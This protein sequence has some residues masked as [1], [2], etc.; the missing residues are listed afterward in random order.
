MNFKY[1][2][3]F[4][5]ILFL[6]GCQYNVPEEL[7][8]AYADLPENIDF[9]YHVKPILSDRCYACH[10]PD[11]NTR[12]AGLRLDVEEIAFKMLESGNTAFA[13][14][15]PSDS[16][17]IER[18]LSDNPEIQMPPPESNLSLSKTE[19]AI[20]IKWVEQGAKWSNHWAF[21][22]P[23]TQ[24]VP[25]HLNQDWPYHNEIDGFI[26]EKLKT[27]KFSPSPRSREGKINSKGNNGFNWVTSL[28]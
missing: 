8:V 1:F 2:G 17:C 6:F 20:L 12:K 23:K 18:I 16:E 21:L 24:P 9:N 13:K 10:G 22:K 7:E 19:K 26:Q 4:F 27:N 28:H 3:L 14:G 15:S 25:Q 5:L 11:E